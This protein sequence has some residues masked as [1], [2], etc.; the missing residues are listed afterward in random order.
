VGPPSSSCTSGSSG[1]IEKCP[2]RQFARIT[3]RSRRMRLGTTPRPDA[4][5][6]KLL[7]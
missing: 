2:F 7:V 1:P 5:H 3:G 4:D 6:G